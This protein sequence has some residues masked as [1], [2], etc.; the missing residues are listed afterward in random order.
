[1]SEPPS[2][3]PAPGRPLSEKTRLAGERIIA[4][5]AAKGANNPTCPMCHHTQFT[6]GA[7]TPL[8]VTTN[9]NRPSLGGPSYPF[10]ALVCTTC[11]NT[12][13]INLFN[14]G[15]KQEDLDGLAFEELPGAP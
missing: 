9:V 4:A 10:V 13:L 15:F 11:G 12:Q 2:G 5:L 14:L 8:F 7:F 1:M 6:V 3:T